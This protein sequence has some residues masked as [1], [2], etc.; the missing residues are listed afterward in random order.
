MLIPL[1]VLIGVWG[2]PGRLAR[3]DQ[4]RRL[5]GR[6]LAADA[7]R[8]RRLRP[9]AGHVRPDEDGHEHDRRGSSSASSIAFAIKSPLFPFHGWLPDAYRESPP[10]VAGRALGRRSRR[11]AAYGFL[12]IAIPKF[13]E[14]AHDWRVVDPRARVDLARLR[15]AARVPRARLPRRRRCTRRSRRSG[16][17]TLGLFANNDLGFDGAVLQMVNHGADLDV[18]VPARRDGRAAHRRPAS[19]RCSAAWRA[20]DRRS[21]RV[22]MTVGVIAL[23]VPL[24]TTFAGEFL[25]LAGVF[26]QGWGWAVVGAVAIV[27]AAMYM[28]RR[29]RPCCTRTSGPAV[30]DAALDLRLGEL[31]VVVP[32]VAL[33]ARALGLAE[34][35]QRALARSRHPTVEL[36]GTPSS[37]D[38]DR[39]RRGTRRHADAIDKPH[40]DWF[41][42]SPSLALLAAAGLL[43]MVAVFVPAHD[44]ARSSPAFVCVRRLRGRVRASRSL[45]RRQEP[46]RG[47][48]SSH[49][50]MFRDRW[51]ALAQV[52]IAGCGRRRGARSP[53]ASAGATSTSPSTTRCSPPRAPAWRSS[54]RRRT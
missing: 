35:D 5:H 32:L 12:R 8:D 13:P 52:L 37:A 54:S 23:A 42:L 4:V 39:L 14:P 36:A 38:A 40:V 2:G 31:A 6:R 41:A 44:A 28:L 9:A 7:R 19:S 26:Q 50:A 29:S 48:R 34:R 10:E 53:T 47:T 16:L 20:G 46:A 18:A 24:S 17:I 45:A 3:D 43:L 11:P 33:P 30:S 1:Y 22:L 25:I 27:L 51:A 15:L 49:D 21:R